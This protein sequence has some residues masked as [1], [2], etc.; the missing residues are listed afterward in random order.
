MTATATPE[1]RVSIPRLPEGSCDCHF[2]V[3]DQA[4]YPYGPY[5]HYTPQDAP[6]EDYLASCERFGVTR[7]VLIH[8]TVFGADHRSF[9]D[10]LQRY[11]ARLRGVAVVAPD[12]SDEDIERWHRLGARGTRITT[13]FAGD[14]DFEAIRRIADKVR[15]FGWHLQL[16]VDVVQRPRLVAQ[17]RELGVDVVVDHLGHHEAR[18]LLDSAG[19]ANLRSQIAEGA[20]WAKLS[21]PYRVSAHCERDPLVQR[22]V[23]ALSAA[24]I[25][26]LV[27]GTDW[28]HPHSP[29]A[30]PAEDRLVSLLHDWLP[31]LALRAQVLVQNP[32]RLYWANEAN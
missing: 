29:H 23:D 20:V 21:A 24:N 9:E 18:P 30:V 13:I 3:F 16:L 10:I 26:Q 14:P 17:V 8:P 11:P 7:G 1:D 27:W 32:T 5:R 15:P 12:T 31:D 6:L 28:P 19:F 4:R 2:H 25:H 22:I